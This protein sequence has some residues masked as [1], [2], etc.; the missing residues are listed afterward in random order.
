MYLHD[1][2]TRATSVETDASDY[3]GRAAASGNPDFCIGSNNGGS[4]FDGVLSQARVWS[5]K[6]TSSELDDTRHRRLTS[7]EE[8]DANLKGLFR[9]EEGTGDAIADSSDITRT[10]DTISAVATGNKFTRASGSFVDDGW[11]AGM[12][13]V[14][15]GFAEGGNVG[16]FVVSTVDATNLAVTG[17]TLVDEASV[18]TAHLA[19]APL[20]TLVTWIP[21]L[22]GGADI[23]GTPK[24][25]AYGRV[26]SVPPLLVHLPTNIYLLSQQPWEEITGVFREV[27]AAGHLVLSTPGGLRRIAAGDVFF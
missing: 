19:S 12:T 7:G 8:A 6:R 2:I 4:F 20:A 5:V 24:P 18:A 23:V 27:D 11:V 22:E 1:L 17:L 9:M 14:S 3:T 26:E 10:D 15:W 16:T 25:L 21:A 13:G